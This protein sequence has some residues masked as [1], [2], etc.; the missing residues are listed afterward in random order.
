[1]SDSGERIT[2]VPDALRDEFP[3]ELKDAAMAGTER[4]GA[5]ESLRL[6]GPPGTGKSTQSALRIGTLAVGEPH[7]RPSEMTVVTY[8][9]S[10]A[11]TIRK[12]LVEWGAVEVPDGVDPS[13]SRS[14]NPFQF[15]TTIHAAAARAT[16]FLSD[17]DSEDPLS[18]MADYAAKR[19]F[20]AE[21]GIDFR[22]PKPWLETRWTVFEDLYQYAKDNL[23]DV[24]VW[25][26]ID[27]DQLTPLRNDNRAEKR[28][29]D[30]REEWG[31]ATSFDYVVEQ[32]RE[33]KR[34]HDIFDFY[35]L[36]EAAVAGSLPPTRLVVIDE[37][38]DSTPLMAAVCERW[39]DAAETAIVAGDPDQ[40]VNGYA[41]ASPRFF[42][43]LGDRVDTELPI[44]R[45]DRS[46]R[47]PDEHF[48]AAARVL[49]AER[50]VPALETAGPGE[51][52][53]HGTPR[54]E[55]NGEKWHFPGPETEGS[56]YHLWHTYGPEVMFLTRTQK[57]ADGI[58]AALDDQG[59]IY[60]S[61]SSVGG[62]WE[63]RLSLLRAL[64]IVEDVAPN[65]GSAATALGDYM[66]DGEESD[67]SKLSPT[68]RALSVEDARRALEY[69]HGRYIDSDR[70]VW[71]S[72]LSEFER[73][74]DSVPLSAF[75]EH[76]G[77]KWWLRYNRGRGSI[78]EL[79]RLGERDK[80][81]LRA[82]WN[83][84]DRFDVDLEDVPTRILTIHASKGAESTDVVVVDGIT[85][86]IRDSVDTD[87]GA[88]ENEA[89]VWYVALTRASERLHVLRDAFSYT[90]EYLP[91]DL[92]PQ[93]A[94]A[95]VAD[96]GVRE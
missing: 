11:D 57:Q 56:A 66:D 76:V 33:F 23:L 17:L 49:R 60:R 1:M 6:H 85:G 48:A 36:L 14:E 45:L 91:R 88:R 21:M 44:A 18:G 94:R 28:L 29:D 30:F 24:G 64:D 75:A 62:S 96:G 26:H 32:W 34:K 58:A 69:T 74:D 51:I 86:E 59:V 70:D 10:L 61:Q 92:E 13:S 38:H 8:R 90:H 43:E 25:R 39:I 93:A 15:W 68:H 7:I 72:W 12:R 89:R 41:G 19:R 22:P 35:E 42:E 65:S 55:H 50:D 80:D 84:Y 79:T 83:R 3:P 54:Y 87:A 73:N 2:A 67:P 53:R 40:V 71:E 63:T 46:W 27:D 4:A 82:A 37:Y 16:G 78:D 95:A 31:A 47:C 81:A 77:E 5:D 20:C 52:L 9:R